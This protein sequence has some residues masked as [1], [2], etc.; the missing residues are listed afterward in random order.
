MVLFERFDADALLDT[1]DPQQC[2]WRIGVPHMYAALVESQR[3]RPR[4][5]DALRFCVV[6]GDVCPLELQQDFANMFGVR[7]RSF[8]VR[9]RRLGL[10]PSACNLDPSAVPHRARS[11]GW[12]M[13]T[14]HRRR[15]AGSASC[16]FAAQRHCRL[17]VRA[18]SD[19]RPVR[20]LV[21]HR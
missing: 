2:S 17:L 6:A 10:S 14:E 7:L 11:F 21:P 8:W 12:S 5:V 20:R 18:G 13:T 4:P 19:R 1:I 9:W 15:V 3:T 16:S